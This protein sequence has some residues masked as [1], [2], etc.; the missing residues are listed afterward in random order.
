M[1]E[2]EI[3]W[4]IISAI[5]GTSIK[6]LQST[7]DVATVSRQGSALEKTFKPVVS[8]LQAETQA[9]HDEAVVAF[10]GLCGAK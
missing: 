4:A 9:A 8:G 5:S 3:S 2:A 1:A 6:M 10:C 7:Y